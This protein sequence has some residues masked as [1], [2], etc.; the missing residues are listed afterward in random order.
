MWDLGG[1]SSLQDPKILNE[2]TSMIH[3]PY[4][5]FGHNKVLFIAM[6]FNKLQETVS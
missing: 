4:N 3:I 2:L 5:Q 6:S 1:Y